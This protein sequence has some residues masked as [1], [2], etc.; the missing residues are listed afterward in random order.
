MNA[1]IDTLEQFTSRFEQGYNSTYPIKVMN[2]TIYE[3][4]MYEWTRP[5][6]LRD[7][8]AECKAL[9][10]EKDP[11]DTGADEEVSAF[12]KNV[13]DTINALGEEYLSASDVSTLRNL[14]YKLIQPLA[15]YSPTSG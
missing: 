6:G 7:Q 5:G 8:V 15:I 13:T 4:A 3:S 1:C 9:A 12:C 11:N 2:E 10:A 14:L